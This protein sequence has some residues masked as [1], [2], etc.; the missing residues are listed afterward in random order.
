[1][2]VLHDEEGCTKV[3]HPACEAPEALAPACVLGDFL[4]DSIYCN[5]V[6]D[7]LA[8]PGTQDHSRVGVRTRLLV[9]TTEALGVPAISIGLRSVMGEYCSVR[10]LRSRTA[11]GFLG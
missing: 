7:K 1:V 4:G 11:A 10:R 6:T 9:I 8:L 5:A 3:G 2:D